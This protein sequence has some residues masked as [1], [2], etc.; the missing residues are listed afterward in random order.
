MTIPVHTATD[1]QAFLT[2]AAEGPRLD[3]DPVVG[4]GLGEP[5][6]VVQGRSGETA[7]AC[8]VFI[9]AMR[10]HATRTDGGKRKS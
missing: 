3:L 6:A 2:T 10:A 9:E 7:P 4:T 1:H 8:K 5:G